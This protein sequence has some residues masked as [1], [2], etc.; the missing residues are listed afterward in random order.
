MIKRDECICKNFYVPRDNASKR[1]FCEGLF[2]LQ[3]AAVARMYTVMH[4]AVKDAD[5]GKR[6]LPR[7]L[8]SHTAEGKHLVRRHSPTL[9]GLQADGCDVHCPSIHE[10]GLDVHRNTKE[11]VVEDT[12]N[13]CSD[14]HPLDYR[15]YPHVRQRLVHPCH[16][17]QDAQPHC[18]VEGI[19]CACWQRM[20]LVGSQD[21]TLLMV[22]P[23]NMRVVVCFQLLG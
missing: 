23:M 16:G 9:E 4:D 13:L 10:T 3:A 22:G 11:R 7:V 2:F 20:Y 18:S 21:M 17:I 15:N 1:T 12:D 19:P 8:R 14:L 5:G 6:K